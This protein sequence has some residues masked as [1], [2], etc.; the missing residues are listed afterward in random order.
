MPRNHDDAQVQGHVSVLLI[1]L[2]QRPPAIKFTRPNRCPPALR[3]QVFSRAIVC[4]PTTPEVS[5]DAGQPRP[6][7][8][9]SPHASSKSQQ[10]HHSAATVHHLSRRRFCA[11]RSPTSHDTYDAIVSIFI[12][13]CAEVG[14]GVE[15]NK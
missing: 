8:P 5:T 6:L 7:V 11:L 4:Q 13:K 2:A 15:R 14:R 3:T 10:F 9:L 1:P 12:V